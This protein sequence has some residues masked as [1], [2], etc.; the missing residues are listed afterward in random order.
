MTTSVSNQRAINQVV[1][2]GKVSKDLKF[3][4][5]LNG[6]PVLQFSLELDGSDEITDSP[7]RGESRTSQAIKK[8]G[9]RSLIPIVVYGSLAQLRS[10]LQSGDHVWIQ[11]R[12]HQRRWKTMEGRIRDRLEVIALELHPIENQPMI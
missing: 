3:H 5:Q 8:E 2:T 12:L 10:T 4:Y 7:S 6:T 9:Q 1:L 11:G